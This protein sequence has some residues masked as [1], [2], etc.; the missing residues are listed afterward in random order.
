MNDTKDIG[1]RKTV[2]MKSV[3]GISLM[4]GLGFSVVGCSSIEKLNPLKKP[5]TVETVTEGK[6]MSIEAF[7]QKLKPSESLAGIDFYLPEA[8]PVADWPMMAGPSSGTPEHIDA[9]KSFNVAWSQSIG[10]GS[11]EITEVMAQPVS[12]GTSLFTL[13][14]GA[15]VC[16]F[17][18]E[19]GR[20][21]WCRDLNPKLKKDKWAFGGGLALGGDKLYV[22]TGYRQL[23]VLDKTT[24][25]VQFEKSVDVPVHQS[26]IITDKLVIVTDVENQVT[27]FDLTTYEQ[28]W[29]YQ[30]LVEP[31]R[32]L[33]SSGGVVINNIL[34]APFSSGEVVALDIS[35]GNEIWSEAL[36]RSSRRQCLIR[37]PRYSWTSRHRQRRSL[38]RKPFRGLCG[39]G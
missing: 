1:L 33:K 37:D 32:L 10:Q 7:E 20:Q 30:A 11:A 25:K 29:T 26:P 18:A 13:D 6:R 4:L 15:R 3:L 5:E 8:Q 19:S 35:N 9:A 14:G 38:C 12:D 31:A 16:A 22:A 23:I 36:S 17:A 24:G 39:F 34:Y 21:S 2:F 27:A 28:V